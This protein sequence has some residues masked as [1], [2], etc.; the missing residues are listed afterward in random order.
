MMA[1]FSARR[2]VCSATSSM[3]ERI[4]PIS[5]IFEL[6]APITRT[7]SSEESLMRLMPWMVLAMPSTPS[8]AA[9]STSSDRRAVSLALVS[10]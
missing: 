6:S 4:L 9:R 3:T 2:L 7:A 10:T 1:A 5:P 8:D